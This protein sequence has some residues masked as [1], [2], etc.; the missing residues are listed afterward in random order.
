MGKQSFCYIVEQKEWFWTEGFPG[1]SFNIS[2]P[3]IKI[4]DIYINQKRVGL[5]KTLPE[6]RFR[7]LPQKISEWL[8]WLVEKGSHRLSA[9]VSWPVIQIKPGERLFSLR[10]LCIFICMFNYF[11]LST[12]SLYYPLFKLLQINFT[13][14]SLGSKMFSE[15]VT[16]FEE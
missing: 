2:I 8:V 6:W 14:V 12:S 7:F 11:I 3:Q 5:L 10:L 4:M 1:D 15:N 13:I 9:V 16:K